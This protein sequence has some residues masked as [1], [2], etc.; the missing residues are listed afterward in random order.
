MYNVKKI[1]YSFYKRRSMLYDN[2]KVFAFNQT[3]VSLCKDIISNIGWTDGEVVLEPFAGLDGFYDNLPE[4]VVKHRCEIRDGL[5]FR[6]FDYDGIKPETIITNPPFD[7]GE[8]NRVRKN[9]FYLIVKFFAQKHYI[10]RIILLCSS[11]CFDSLTAKRMMEL[12]SHNL[13]ITKITAVRIRK[14]RGAYY[15]VE[16]GRQ[17]NP[18]FDYYLGNY[19]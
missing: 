2:D 1:M 7:L 13:Y 9:D 11:G 12:N 5:D 4:E 16:M 15:L 19:E 17:Y 6:D 10:K 3:P 18:S 8:S 14:W